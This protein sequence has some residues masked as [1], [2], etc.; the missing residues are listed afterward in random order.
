MAHPV[1]RQAPSATAFGTSRALPVSGALL[2]LSTAI[3][4]YFIYS[5]PLDSVQGLIQKILYVH[6][7]C[8]F[9]AYAGFVLTAA[10]CHYAA[11]IGVVQL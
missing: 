6:V 10:S 11:V 1:S 3:W 5:A 2:A 8:W 9:A 4:A 7:P